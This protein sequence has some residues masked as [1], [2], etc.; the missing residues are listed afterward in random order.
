M[1]LRNDIC[2]IEISVDHTFSIGSADNKPYDKVYYAKDYSEQDKDYYYKA[3]SLRI[4]THS[5]IYR[6]ALIGSCYSDD[7]DCAVLENNVLTVLLDDV[8]IRINVLTGELIRTV[9]TEYI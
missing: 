8:V 9:N 6:I 1:T 2:R 7:E 3:L 5:E 4:E